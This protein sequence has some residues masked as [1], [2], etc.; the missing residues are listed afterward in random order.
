MAKLSINAEPYAWPCTGPVD[1]SRVA[2]LIVDMQVDFCGYGG[3]IDNQ[4]IDI[5]PARA[6]IEPIQRLRRAVADRGDMRIIQTREGH[7]PEL[8]DLPA[9][10]RI[11]SEAVSP[12][13]GSPGPCGRI[14]TRGEPGWEIV[15]E[16]TPEPGE[17]VVDK[18][19]KG[20]FYATDLEHILRTSGI[21]HLIVAGLTT[22]VCVHTTIR[23]ANDRGIECLLI[24]DGTMATQ[25]Q[26][27]EASLSMT[28]MQGGLFGAVTDS[29]RAIE[30][31]SV[32]LTD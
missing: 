3:F 26:H 20:S 18:P 14:L 29:N 12:G 19:G 27:Y 2:L 28:S 15:P 16:L 8:V 6:T 4:G 5:E 13:I 1:A 9:S 22:D 30:S 17:I 10:K 7:R 32:S 24:S 23:E 11:R 25:R 21:D 31:F